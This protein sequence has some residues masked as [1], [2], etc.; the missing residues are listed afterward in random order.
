[1][2]GEWKENKSEIKGGEDNKV[3]RTNRNVIW[4]EPK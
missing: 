2:K 1:M 4:T 3:D